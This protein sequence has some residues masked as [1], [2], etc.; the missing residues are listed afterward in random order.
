M[1]DEFLFELFHA[2]AS[3]GADGDHL[4]GAIVFL[5][6]DGACVEDRPAAQVNR[7]FA[8]KFDQPTVRYVAAGYQ[9]A[10]QVNYVTDVEV[11]EIFVL[12][13]GAEDL[14]HRTTPSWDKIS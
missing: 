9:L 7:K 12:D 3:G 6:H 2:H 14:F 8:L 1:L 5:A 13:W 4:E 10:R 11:C